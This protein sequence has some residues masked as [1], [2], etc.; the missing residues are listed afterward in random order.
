[1]AL[2]GLPNPAKTTVLAYPSPC[3]LHFTSFYICARA[4]QILGS[5]GLIGRKCNMA[6]GG[7]PNAA[8]TQ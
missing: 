7:P 8:K 5:L 3:M 4:S 6:M 2:G 1:M